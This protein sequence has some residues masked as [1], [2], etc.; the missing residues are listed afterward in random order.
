MGLLKEL[1]D[2]AIAFEADDIRG[3]AAKG[4]KNITGSLT[5]NSENDDITAGADGNDDISKTDDIFGTKDTNPDN[6]NQNSQNQNQ[7]NQDNQNN[8]NDDLGGGDD[9]GLGDLG[10]DDDSGG[11]GDNDDSFGDD[12]A[13]SVPDYY[14]KDK[15]KENMIY[16]YNIIMSNIK[17]ITELQ[18]RSNDAGGIEICNKVLE[19]LQA[20]AEILYED[21]TKKINDLSY[22]ELKRDYITTKRVFDLCTEMMSKHFGNKTAIINLKKK[23]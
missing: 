16:F 15:L 21:L 4:A 10:S 13:E 3:Q 17:S 11:M 20:I 22:E 18:G 2:Y 14:D 23:K 9:G 6:Q 7:N 8:N 1:E 12:N 5:G 19:I